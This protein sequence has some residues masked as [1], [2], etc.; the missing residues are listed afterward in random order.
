M[1]NDRSAR[2]WTYRLVTPL[3]NHVQAFLLH[4]LSSLPLFFS[5]CVVSASKSLT[6]SLGI[7]GR[8][9]VS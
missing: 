1:M 2:L 9:V 7:P 8:T 4:L 5:S 3:L 6:A